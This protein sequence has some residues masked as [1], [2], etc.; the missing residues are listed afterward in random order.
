M[1][2]ITANAAAA[3]VGVDEDN[4]RLLRLIGAY[5]LVVERALHQYENVPDVIAAEAVM[6]LVAY[7][8]DR[9]IAGGTSWANFW[10]NSGAAAILRPYRKFTGS[11]VERQP[12]LPQEVGGG[13]GAASAG[14]A[15][16]GYTSRPGR[17]SGAVCNA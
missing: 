7:S 6:L 1:A 2:R 3:E 4:P 10:V 5:D 15:W 13:A 9:Q 8:F 12:G 14:G 17:D 16:R 11:I